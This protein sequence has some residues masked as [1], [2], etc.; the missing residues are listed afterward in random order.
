MKIYKYVNLKYIYGDVGIYICLHICTNV[1]M[2]VYRVAFG[3]SNNKGDKWKID[4][5]ENSN[6]KIQHNHS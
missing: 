5:N 3:N 6:N 2:Y 1:N 4:I